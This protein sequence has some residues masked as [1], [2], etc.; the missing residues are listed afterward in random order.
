MNNEINISNEVKIEVDQA[1]NEFEE[2][3]SKPDPNPAKLKKLFEIIKKGAGY[4][5]IKVIEVL[6]K[7]VFGI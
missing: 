4:G 7:K 5:I 1:I 6:L 2:E 3:A